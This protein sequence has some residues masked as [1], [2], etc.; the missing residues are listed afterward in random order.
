MKHAS[1]S[2]R[3]N[4][5]TSE[6]FNHWLNMYSLAAGAAGVGMLALAQP[7]EAEIVYT[8]ADVVLSGRNFSRHY[9]LDLNNDGSPDFF[10][11]AFWQLSSRKSGGFSSIYAEPAKGN[12]IA[13]YRGNAW[14]LA[15]GQSIGK[16]LKF[17][18]EQLAWMDTYFGSDLY[19]GGHWKN[20][21]NRYLGLRFQ[22]AGET[23]YGWARLTIINEAPLTATLTGYAYETVAN[24]PIIAG[25]TSDTDEA[26]LAP[27]S[28]SPFEP[29]TRPVTL[30]LLALGAPSLS[31]W[32]R[33]EPEAG[34]PAD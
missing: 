22:I 23:H 34:R 1:S 9:P 19:M 29:G 26:L 4:Q 5:Q 31:I 20:A 16:N 33:S 21:T 25:K 11:H 30:G 13:G 3:A 6:R 28:V 14:A 2:S 7:A 15:A 12:R 32:R 27:T 8:S 24:T 10:L 17:S 18:G